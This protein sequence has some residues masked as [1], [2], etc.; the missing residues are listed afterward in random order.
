MKLRYIIPLVI[1]SIVF[2]VGFLISRNQSEKEISLIDES[3]SPQINAQQD[4]SKEGVV[5]EQNTD[6]IEN[7]TQ[8][9]F[10]YIDEE[11]CG[12]AFAVLSRSGSTVTREQ[13]DQR[14]ESFTTLLN[15]NPEA[16]LSRGEECLFIAIGY[17]EVEATELVPKYLSEERA[18]E[19]GALVKKQAQKTQVEAELISL[20]AGSLGDMNTCMEGGAFIEEPSDNGVMCAGKEKWPD[21][22]KVGHLWGGCSFTVNRKLWEEREKET[23]NETNI[24]YTYCAKASTGRVVTCASN[25]QCN[26]NVQ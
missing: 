19:I 20:L 13:F 26:I 8:K 17:D 12:R 3:Q 11:V 23:T 22:S 10:V 2:L 5:L 7:N 4:Q 9:D 15:L 21:L 24:Y 16:A 6:P 1:L 18:K 14:V 25:G